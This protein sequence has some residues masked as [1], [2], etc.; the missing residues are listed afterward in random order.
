MCHVKALQ[1]KGFIKREGFSARAVELVD[2]KFG[3][4]CELREE[5]A[6][7][8]Q[9]IEELQERLGELQQI[10]EVKDGYIRELRENEICRKCLQEMNW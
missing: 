6:Q 4:N 9:R 10:L 3:G 8:H 2:F 7:L 5:N 1:T